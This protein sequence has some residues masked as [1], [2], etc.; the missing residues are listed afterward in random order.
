LKGKEGKGPGGVLKEK[1][2]HK[3]GEGAGQ[4]VK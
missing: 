1:K 3:E 2:S 4:G